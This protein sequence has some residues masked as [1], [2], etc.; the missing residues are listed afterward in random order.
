[1]A[2]G[3]PAD[4]PEPDPEFE[5]MKRKLPAHGPRIVSGLL[6]HALLL[7]DFGHL[8][9]AADLRSLWSARGEGLRPCGGNARADRRSAGAPKC[10]SPLAVGFQPLDISGLELAAR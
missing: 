2:N 5:D 7:E 6:H 10:S 9:A 8:A 4:P 3:Q 1:M